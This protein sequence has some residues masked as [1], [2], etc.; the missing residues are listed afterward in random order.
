MYTA[1]YANQT[2]NESHEPLTLNDLTNR[3]RV[4]LS[5]WNLELIRLER[6]I[7]RL[8]QASNS[9]TNPEPINVPPPRTVEARATYQRLTNPNI[10]S[11]IHEDLD[12]MLADDYTSLKSVYTS[13]HGAWPR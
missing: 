7:A 5:S 13:M 11:N 8:T 6:E 1:V 10:T 2:T 3:L 4:N 12:P 9:R